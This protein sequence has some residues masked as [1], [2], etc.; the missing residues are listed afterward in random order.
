[1]KL[2]NFA[3]FLFGFA[4]LADALTGPMHPSLYSLTETPTAALAI[5]PVV[6][7]AYRWRMKRGK[8]ASVLNLRDGE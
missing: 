2:S 6:L 4:I 8:N 1:M 5:G 7:L 3:L